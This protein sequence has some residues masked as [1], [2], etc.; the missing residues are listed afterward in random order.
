MQSSPAAVKMIESAYS[1]PLHRV[2]LASGE[3]NSRIKPGLEVVATCGPANVEFVKSLG[4][5]IV[6]DYTKTSLLEWVKQ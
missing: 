3:C 6:L 4:A 2:V 5:E 1:S